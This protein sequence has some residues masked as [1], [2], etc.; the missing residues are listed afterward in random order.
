[1]VRA[2]RRG[3]KDSDTIETRS[4]SGHPDGV[5]TQLFCLLNECEYFMRFVPTD[6]DTKHMLPS[7]PQSRSHVRRGAPDIKV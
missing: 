7:S 4:A 6:S 5:E 1:V 3:G 2:E